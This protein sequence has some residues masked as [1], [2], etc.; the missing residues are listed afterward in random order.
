MH[1]KKKGLG[2][3]LHGLMLLLYH[4]QVI[5]FRLCQCQ[6]FIT[7]DYEFPIDGYMK[8][9]QIDLEILPFQHA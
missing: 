5:I 4:E 2:I 8:T 6:D 3:E 1:S 9:E 7:F